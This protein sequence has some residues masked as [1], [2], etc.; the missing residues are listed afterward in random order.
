MRIYFCMRDDLDY[1]Y[2][3]D[4]QNIYAS[5]TECID[6]DPSFW[7]R[8]RKVR[9]EFEAMSEKLWK[10]A[11]KKEKDNEAAEEKQETPTP[12]PWGPA[13]MTFS[14]NPASIIH[15]DRHIDRDRAQVQDKPE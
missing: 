6:V 3:D 14:Y 2:D 9:Q 12:P 7:A 13:A 10:L 5:E 15:I 8:F 4:R 1:S 11:K